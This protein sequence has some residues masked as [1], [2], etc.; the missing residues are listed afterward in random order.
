MARRLFVEFMQLIEEQYQKIEMYLPKQRGNVQAPNL[1]M[2]NDLLYMAENGCKWRGLAGS[3]RKV[4][5]HSLTDEP[6]GEE[7]HPAPSV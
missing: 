2:L 3:L 6:L 1:Q 4:V 5:Y 7:R